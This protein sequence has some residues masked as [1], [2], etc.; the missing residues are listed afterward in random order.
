[1][2]D[3]FKILLERIDGVG[4]KVDGLRLEVASTY[5]RESDCLSRVAHER[6]QRG[7]TVKRLWD[8]VDNVHGPDIDS[9]KSRVS[10]LEVKRLKTEGVDEVKSSAW[11]WLLVIAASVIGATLSAYVKGCL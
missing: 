6:E 5:A 8:K 3:D 2:T 11:K 9:L 4:E 10:A 7:E 1:M